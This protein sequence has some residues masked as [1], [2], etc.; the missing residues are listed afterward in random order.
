MAAALAGLVVGG[1]CLWSAHL[2][3][4]GV[5]HDLET[6]AGLGLDAPS[7]PAELRRAE[8]APRARL[9]LARALLTAALD[10]RNDVLS[11]ESAAPKRLHRLDTASRLARSV[12]DA[13]PASW[14]AAMVA[15]AATYLRWSEAQDPRL[16][17]DYRR[18]ES[19]LL[20]ALGT[21]PDRRVPARY[22]AAAYLELWPALSADKR[23]LTRDLLAD[24]F[25]DR[26]TFGRL[27]DS[28]LNVASG[29]AALAPIPDRSWAWASLRARAGRRAD[30]TE[31]CD[32]W[33]RERGALARELRARLREAR[34]LSAGGELGKAR[35]TLLGILSDAPVDR[36]FGE[37]VEQTMELLPHGPQNGTPLAPAVHWLAWAM[38]R[39]LTGGAQPLSPATLARL[40]R[41]AF[42]E[43]SG[44]EGG[45]LAAW[46]DLAADRLERAERLEAR[47]VGSWQEEW[48]PY[49]LL[50]ARYLQER[51]RIA[52]ARRAL[53]QVHPDWR[54]HPAYL[55]A[56]AQL[57]KPDAKAGAAVG[58]GAAVAS[59]PSAVA[60]PLDWSYSG[61]IA[62]LALR[63]P[64]TAG[65]LR[66]MLAEIPPKGGAL[67]I[68]WDGET[69]SCRPLAPGSRRIEV[70][71]EA[72][73]GLH[74]IEL[75]LLNGGSL[76][77]GSVKLLP[78]SPAG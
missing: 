33:R 54:T 61:V 49:F 46:V 44:D 70:P 71:L 11:A 58:P 68:R 75:E 37:I 32:A 27:L 35:K 34:D 72:T 7:L 66:I 42:R 36:A 52:E 57:G 24:A 12:L 9:R 43:S 18:W 10:E 31:Y 77:P 4:R 2:V 62:R 51:G 74:Q 65:G 53:A 50:K 69:V 38:A 67:A 20:Y 41:L 21:A 3:R 56:A 19:P 8:S 30:W 39:D 55:R 29:A 14:E 25:Q 16:L 28:W 5:A 60:T 47:S 17:Q 64:A 45:P 1:A 15:G 63:V 48:A 76:Y 73:R 40:R 13:H 78:P 23:A 6:A 22:L 26:A 59:P